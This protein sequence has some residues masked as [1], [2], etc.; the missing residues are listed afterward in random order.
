M[1]SFAKGKISMWRKRFQAFGVLGLGLLLGWFLAGCGS[2]K[3]Q[4]PLQ[5]AESTSAA[6]TGADPIESSAM[7]A[8]STE[9][10]PAVALV[11]TATNGTA[12]STFQLVLVAFQEGR[13]EA[14][15]DFLPPSHQAEVEQL[16]QAFA[17]KMDPDL[18]SELFQL[19]NKSANLLKS[20][21]ELILSMDGVK[22]LP[23]IDAIKP[24]W[25]GITN[26]L[27][28]VATS[29]IADLK[30][31][32]RAN[33]Q[34]LLA[35][36]SR[37]LAGMQLPSFGDVEVTTV[38]ATDEQATL[39]YRDAKNAE[40]KQVEFVRVEGKWLPKSIV[41]GWP[42]AMADAKARL[43]ELPSQ[44]ASVKP[45]ALRQ[46]ASIAGMLDQLQGAKTKDEFS[47]AAVPLVYTVMFGAQMAQ[48]ALDDAATTPRQGNAVHLIIN[49]ELTDGE[50]TRLKTAVFDSLGDSAANTDYEFIPNDGKT[51]CRFV[52]ITD[53][54]SLLIVLEKHFEG[55][56][57]RLDAETKTIFVDGN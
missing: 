7:P 2:A 6:K 13:L 10:S 20:K 24:Y 50:L 48:Q 35:S 14:V 41:T 51:R 3:T 45:E 1:I 29:E 36:G 15:F 44:L 49:R 18:W 21:K 22:K 56:S 19:L 9:N 26:G 32:K 30:Q 12:E 16:L 11:S 31:L 39:S 57:V 34:Q 52:P 23:Q 5:P 54:P 17:D 4:T 42:V 46:M 40:P 43:A 25:E 8:E 37:L 47:A 28:D 33:A 53:V 38:Q 55:T 27:R